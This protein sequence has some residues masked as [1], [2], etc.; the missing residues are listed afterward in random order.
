MLPHK[1]VTEAGGD[2]TSGSTKE[3]GAA[4]RKRYL[5]ASKKEKTKL[6]SEFCTVTGYHRK[7][8]VRLLRRPPRV[9]ERRGRAPRY[10]LA[11]TQALRKL[12]EASDHLCSKRLAPFIPEL[13]DS[14]ERHDELPL[15]AEIKELVLKVSASTIDRLLRPYRR[16]GLRRPYTSNTSSSSIKSQIPL[17]TFSEWEN[18]Q[19]GSLQ[20]DLVLHC[21]ESTEGF[22]LTTLMAV[23][24]A[25]GWHECVPIWG[26]G[27]DRVGGG[28]HQVQSRLPFALRELHTDN[29]SEFINDGLYPYC[30]RYAIRF[31][32]GRP[33]KK[34]DQA[35]V[36]Q[37]N[38][39]VVRRLVGYHRYSTKS[40]YEQMER[41]YILVGR[42]T[43]FFQPI[44]KLVHKERIG[45]KVIKRYDVAKTPY[46]LLLETGILQEVKRRSLEEQYQSLNPVQLKSQ[47]DAALEK[48][49][50]LAQREEP[51][52]AQITTNHGNTLSDATS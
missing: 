25:T 2:M 46:Q 11:V 4:M 50:K 40:A 5:A 17:R 37:K 14:L 12:W 43:N 6:L 49:W 15:E 48:L 27:K 26:K 42:Y 36:E 10:G 20:A 28:V 29:G 13:V 39:S 34:N 23:D 44:A 22:Y 19:P 18:V 1:T 8:A 3:Y 47:I 32:R 7:A 41:L 52:K 16:R 21:G 9:R 51:I 38:W 33:Y 30:Q 35:Y 45:A 24:V 31:T